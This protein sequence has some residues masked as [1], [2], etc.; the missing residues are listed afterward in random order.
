MAA[1][2]CFGF[3]ACSVQIS[4]VTINRDCLDSGHA[5]GIVL[6]MWTYLELVKRCDHKPNG[7]HVEPRIEKIFTNFSD[8]VCEKLGNWIFR[9]GL[10]ITIL[11]V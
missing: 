2:S 5:G 3:A 7:A 1:W 8:N 11:G 10:N 6:V 9:Y 4:V